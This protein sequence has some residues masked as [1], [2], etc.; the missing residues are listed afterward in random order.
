MYADRLNQIMDLL[1][2][3]N[4]QIAGYEGFDA[5]L[6]THLRKGSRVPTRDGS[7][8]VH[9]T[10]GLLL[11]AAEHDQLPALCKLTGA[12]P[13]A[14]RD[15]IREQI[16]D[17]LYEGIP[18][19]R[20]RR[21][22]NSGN[23]AVV[24]RSSRIDDHR[25]YGERFDIAMN[26]GNLSNQRLSA[27]AHV[28]ASVVSRYRTGIRTL[29][30]NPEMSGF[31]TGIIWQRIEDAGNLDKL[32][33]IMHVSPEECNERLF[34]NWLRQSEDTAEGNSPAAERL[35]EAFDTYSTEN[36]GR[37]PSLN[38]LD[39]ESI[40]RDQR[41][42]YFGNNGLREAVI[43]FLIQAVKE[44]PREL[45]LYSSQS[46]NWMT[47]DPG[48][49]YRWAALMR[50][51]VKNGTHIRIIHNIDRDLDEMNNAIISWLPLYMSGM[52]ESF[53]SSLSRGGLFS[54]TVFLNPGRSCI[55]A[56][57]A[58]GAE[59]TGFY[60]YDTKPEILSCDE[61][62][63][64]QLFKSAKPLVKTLPANAPFRS[65]A[66]LT[67][68]SPTLTASTL[69]ASLRE[70]FPGETI[71][72]MGVWL[73]ETLSDK[74]KQHVCECVTLISTAALKSGAI[75]FDR[76][77][78]SES[79]QYTKEQYT[80]HIRNLIR[81]MKE[82]PGFRI[83]PLPDVPF[84]NMKLWISE[85][86]VRIT[87]AVE[88]FVSFQFSHPLMCSAFCDYAD[89]LVRRYRKNR[90]TLIRELTQDYLREK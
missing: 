2:A 83:I 39:A 65:S 58:A 53:Y 37:L 17:W 82:Y 66:D 1:G 54:Q 61:K 62:Q 44:K 70:I 10:N 76:M 88:P 81:L 36:G 78:G 13:H 42:V 55:R 23:R 56:F 5:S 73:E 34:L 67:I 43:R 16:L 89:R 72:N 47:G 19:T 21:K 11:Y 59:E 49:L 9:V 60:H 79:Y 14:G 57:H 84:V 51:C 32:A 87:R 30:S 7:S 85:D 35:L 15:R 27:L 41:E 64:N 26:L 46:M 71:K 90:R 25:P 48:F 24:R 80:E 68:I 52:I 45:I 28:D 86:C 4:R 38:D 63:L 12:D 33:D 77:P 22:K 69:P 6:L 50:T 31:F 8:S 75:P 18:Q 40:L 74:D 29:Q 20:T 3:K